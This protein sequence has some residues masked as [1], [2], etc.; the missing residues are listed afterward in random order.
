MVPVKHVTDHPKPQTPMNLTLNR[1]GPVVRASALGVLLGLGVVALTPAWRSSRANQGHEGEA[2]PRFASTSGF[3]RTPYL[4]SMGAD[5]ILIAWIA[6]APGSAVVDYG[7]TP[8]YGFSELAES[9]GAR[10][11]ATLR[12]L[13]PGTTYYYRVRAGKRV[14]ADGRGLR[15]TTDPGPQPGRFNFLVTGDVGD[16]RGRQAITAASILRASKPPA[17]GLLCGDIVY[18]KGRSKDYDERLMQPWRELFCTIPIWPALGNHDWKSDPRSNWEREWYLPGNEHYYSFDHGNAHFIALDTRDGEIY[19]R[20]RQV[21]WLEQDLAAHQDADWLFAYFHHPGVTC[22][23][24]GDNDAVRRHFLPLF[25]AYGVDVVFSGH[26]H[27]YERLYPIRNGKPVDMEQDPDYTDPS[28]PIYIVSGAAAKLKRNRPTKACGPTAFAR[29]ELLLW[30]QVF[31]DGNSCV[32]RTWGSEDDV[33]V[34]EVSIRKTLPR[35]GTA[36]GP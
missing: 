28:G 17:L 5:S 31:V 20:R 11:G 4:Q 18:S 25:E 33:L 26:A 24:K 12:G 8:Q 6:S 1:V 34:D 13:Q 27:T 15:F 14:L 19:D 10:H 32:I 36:S 9:Q 2:R 3:E 23:Y 7:P 16:R 21:R 35:A 30:T 29:D 22:T